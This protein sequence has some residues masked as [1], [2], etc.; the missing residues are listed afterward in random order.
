MCTSVTM[1]LKTSSTRC[2]GPFLCVQ[3]LLSI[4]QGVCEGAILGAHHENCLREPPLRFETRTRG[5]SLNIDLHDPSLSSRSV[6]STASSRHYHRKPH[7]QNTG[8]V[9]LKK[10]E[11]CWNV[12]CRRC[13]CIQT[14]EDPRLCET[15]CLIN[16]GI[17]GND[18]WTEWCCGCYL[19]KLCG[20]SV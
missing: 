13:C 5:C 10:G 16:T 17:V 2:I 4:H 7:W 18:P 20:S 9:S 12:G 1:P 3:F 8:R 14:L 19:C 6:N 15:G 11:K